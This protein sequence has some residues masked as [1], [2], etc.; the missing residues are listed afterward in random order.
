MQDL[1]SISAKNRDKLKRIFNAVRSFEGDT[2]GDAT[3]KLGIS[4]TF[5]NSFFKYGATSAPLEKKI[6]A[7][8]KQSSLVAA[9]T[10]LGLNPY[11]TKEEMRQAASPPF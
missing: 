4:K 5:L 1:E 9:I 11:A 3:D 7:Y 10:D 2:L 8:I 6:R